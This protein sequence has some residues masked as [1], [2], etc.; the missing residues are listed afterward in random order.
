MEQYR[1]HEAPPTVRDGD[2]WNL[3]CQ[4]ERMRRR[5]DAA[6]RRA[7]GFLVD[8]GWSGPEETP[9]GLVYRGHGLS[10]R[11]AVEDGP[12][13]VLGLPE[14]PSATLAAVWN[15][16]GLSAPVPRPRVD[17]LT[18][19]LRT[20]LPFLLGPQRDAILNDAARGLRRLRP[21]AVGQEVR[22]TAE[23][24]GGPDA[25]RSRRSPSG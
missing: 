11:L 12:A 8:E 3:R 2:K 18:E 23:R 19:A 13:L 10:V 5:T 25:S 6:G 1:V 22:N 20:V 7:L 9:G 24:P 17:E 16:C 4:H 14:G 21:R 15:A